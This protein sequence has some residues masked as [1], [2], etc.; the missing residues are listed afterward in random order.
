LL[1]NTAQAMQGDLLRHLGVKTPYFSL[2]HHLTVMPLAGTCGMDDLD[3]MEKE[4]YFPPTVSWLNYEGL[5]V[6]LYESPSVGNFTLGNLEISS[7]GLET[8]YL[9]EAEDRIED[10]RH[11]G[12]RSMLMT[13]PV[14][15]P[16]KTQEL[17]RVMQLLKIC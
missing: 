1:T 7:G 10:Y 9:P 12:D 3:V 11:T 14:A 16:G 4:G 8:F 6:K 5:T 13:K 15:L 2:R 17:I